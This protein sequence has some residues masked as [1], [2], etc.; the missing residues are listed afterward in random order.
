[1]NYVFYLIPEKSI[2]PYRFTK[3]LIHD[4]VLSYHHCHKGVKHE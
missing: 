1:M 2:N 3:K 4:I